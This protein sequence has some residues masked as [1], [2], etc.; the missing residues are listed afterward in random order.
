M[1]RRPNQVILQF[2]HRGNRLDDKSNRYKHTCK[3]CGEDFPK[4]RIERLTSHLEHECQAISCQDRRRALFLLRDATTLGKPGKGDAQGHQVFGQGF[5]DMAANPGLGMERKLSGLEALAEA[6]RQIE[7]PRG[8]EEVD[9]RHEAFLDHTLEG[10]CSDA[11]P[12]DVNASATNQPS[13]SRKRGLDVCLYSTKPDNFLAAMLSSSMDARFLSAQAPIAQLTAPFS[14]VMDAPPVTTTAQDASSLSM[15]A[16][17]ASDLE[18]L[19]PGLNQHISPNNDI[20]PDSVQIV[21]GL[22][23]PARFERIPLAETTVHAASQPHSIALSANDGLTNTS[24]ST[25]KMRKQKIRQKFSDSRRLE[26][27]GIRKKGACIRCRM[28]RKTVG[29]SFQ[30]ESKSGL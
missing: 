7:Y 18:A 13:K 17:S 29:T 22:A 21:R 9:M 27:Q 6:S 11:L 3:A 19:L 28:L 23:Q 24:T 1:G 10:V 5:H 30:L 14:Y 8:R 4:G 20:H 2:F 15:I 25:A 12:L 16:A 26:V